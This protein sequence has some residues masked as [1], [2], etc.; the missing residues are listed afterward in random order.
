MRTRFNLGDL[1]DRD[2]GRLDE[3][4]I[5][6]LAGAEPRT[7]SFRALDNM[8]AA[9]ARGLLASGLVRGDRVAILSA[10]RSE[11]LAA[12][13]GA[14]QAGLVA[15]PINYRFPR[16]MTDV[17]LRD[18]GAKIV[19]CDVERLPACPERLPAVVF[20]GAQTSAGPRSFEAFCRPGSFEPVRPADGE[21]AMILYTSGSTGRPKGVVL[22][23][24]SHL[25]V[26]KTR[27]AAQD[28]APHRLLVAAPLYHM[29]AL[30]L[31]KLSIAS[32]ATMVLLPQFT[33]ATYME[34]IA[35]YRCTWL[36]AVPPMIAMV[37]REKALVAGTDFSSVAFLRMGSAPVSPALL[38]AIHRTMPAATVV[39][40][41][42]TTECGPVVFGPHPGGLAQP[43]LSVGYPHPLVS[44]RLVDGSDRQA[45]QGVLEMNSPA[46]MTG[47]HDRPDIPP[48]FAADGFYI[49]G[50]VFRRDGDGF[51]YFV[52][53]TDDM[54]VCGGENIYPGEVEKLLER[55]AA[56]AQACVVPVDD[57]VKGK[58]PVA[59]CV[60]REG[61]AVSEDELKRFALAHAP[62]YMHPRAVWF[63]D[64]LPLTT[65]NKVDRKALLDR[66]AASTLSSGRE[67]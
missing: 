4:A 34:A 54:F 23:H 50:D 61:V 52:G 18:A 55:H 65:T 39:N 43:P 49:T 53:R 30:A 32:G 47:Y 42:G 64:R 40:A 13:L 21:T 6:D 62:A 48:P 66:A 41:Y 19:F 51:H 33:A 45:T 31:A 9:A 12:Y 46:R 29:N 26:V 59:F 14:M 63:L 57:E 17:V 25:W 16:E 8:A 24:A 15:V 5:I 11:Y 58:K 35:R 7:V 20:G 60:R 67:P 22:S 36:T 28:L 10:N 37:L 3:P 56:V 1:I 38:E 2:N 44:L 27:M